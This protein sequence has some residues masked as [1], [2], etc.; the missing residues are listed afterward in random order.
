MLLAF[1]FTGLS[2]VIGVS[3][4]G[5]IGYRKAQE[6]LGLSDG[7]IRQAVS[8]LTGFE[9]TLHNII[10]DDE[11]EFG[12]RA[13]ALGRSVPFAPP[14]DGRMTPQ[15]MEH[16]LA[17]KRRLRSI[18]EEMGADVKADEARPGTGDKTS[19]AFLVKWN[20]FTRVQRLRMAQIDELERQRMSV[21]EYNWVHVAIYRAMLAEGMNGDDRR[22][23]WAAG[24]KESLD[25]SS[26]EIERQLRDAAIPA[27][28]R[29]ELEEIR[30]RIAGRRDV[31]AGIAGVAQKSLNE[32]PAE[33]RELVRRYGRE[34]G[35]VFLAAIDLDS[36][37]FF[38]AIE[39]AQG[40]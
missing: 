2:V 3:T 16:F 9:G 10:G 14:P 1:F 4:G 18:D 38:R 15:Q 31:A 35:D 6:K 26:G 33:N 17:V 28:R 30:S 36:V 32:V 8:T 20:F 34:L 11:S 24:I 39:P 7:T 21:E 29:K 25:R 5:Y 40:E 23:D 12:K 27:A 22:G 37:D 13:A 19:A